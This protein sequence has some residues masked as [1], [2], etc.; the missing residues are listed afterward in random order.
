MPAVMLF[1]RGG[2]GI[3]DIETHD[4]MAR[5]LCRDCEAVVVS[6]STASRR[7]ARS[8]PPSTTRS[9]RPGRWANDHLS[10]FGGSERL[11]VAGDRVGGQVCSGA[12][13]RLDRPVAIRPSTS[14]SRSRGTC[15]LR[16]VNC[17]ICF[18]R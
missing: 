13:P 2:W 17:S 15:R 6:S 10:D 9:P 1:H 11:A 7:S 8:L 12:A 14:S 16:P 18:I 5:S 3:G 4:T